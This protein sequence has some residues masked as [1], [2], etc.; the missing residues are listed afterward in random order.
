MPREGIR[1]H[2]QARSIPS[3]GRDLTFR[4][5]MFEADAPFAVSWVRLDVPGAESARLS[6]TASGWCVE[7]DVV[8][9]ENDTPGALRYRVEVTSEWHTVRAEIEARLGVGE[10]QLSIT[11]E[12][13]GWR[14]NG[15]WVA[16]VADAVDVDL[17]FTPSTNLLPMRRLQLREGV[18]ERV[19]SAW[20]RYPE[21]DLVP[22]EQFYTRVGEL[23]I[24]YESPG[25]TGTIVLD[26][27]SGFP[28]EYPGL[29]RMVARAR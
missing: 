25:L 26:A 18:R 22:L 16:A 2:D 3:G 24:F 28:R 29:W 27:T 8:V 10:W 9:V 4:G 19:V 11:R 7:G 17:A 13:D 1:S 14:R 5:T 21:L 12:D 20:V 15:E 23:E 6:R